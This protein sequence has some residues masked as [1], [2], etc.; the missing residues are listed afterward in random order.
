[1]PPRAVLDLDH[2]YEALSHPRPRYL[3]YTLLEDAEWSLTDP[4]TKI[5][6]WENDL[7]GGAVT[8][9]RREQVYASLYHAHV[10]KLADQGIV[11]FDDATETISAAGNA[12]QVLS[13]LRGIGTVPDAD[14]EEH[15]R[16][17][18]DDGPHWPER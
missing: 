17:E 14:Q 5:A 4:A 7:P 18:M 12:E 9:Y 6:A 1:L 8:E 13:A 2:V 3:C 11:T 10:P 15:A 16:G